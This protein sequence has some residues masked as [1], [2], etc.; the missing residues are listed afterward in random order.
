MRAAGLPD[1]NVFP[2][3][4]DSALHEH[5]TETQTDDANHSATALAYVEAVA[6]AAFAVN[7]NL[8]PAFQYCSGDLKVTIYKDGTRMRS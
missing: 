1:A 7:V 6:G 3:V 2:C 5:G 4:N 8:D